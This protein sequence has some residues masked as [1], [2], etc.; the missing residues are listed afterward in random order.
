[1]GFPGGA[2]VKNSPAS[3]GQ[4][5]ETQARFLGQEDPLEKEMI[6]H[7]SVTAWENFIDRGRKE[8]DTTEPA[9]MHSVLARIE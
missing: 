9:C 3:A 1:M 7:S 6:A 5:Q 4:M 2:V 8:L